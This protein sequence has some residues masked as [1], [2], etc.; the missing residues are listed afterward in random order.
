[1]TVLYSTNSG[2]SGEATN[3]TDYSTLNGT[4]TIP[5]GS[6]TVTL[7]LN[8]VDDSVAEGDETVTLTISSDSHYGPGS[9][10]SATVTIHDDESTVTITATDN[11]ASEPGT[12]KGVFT[13][14]R[15]N[16]G[17]ALAVLYSTNSGQSGAATNGS[18]YSS[19]SGTVTIPSGSSSVALTLIPIDDSVAESD[20]TVTLTISDSSS[21]FKGSPIS[22]TVTIH[23]D[24]PTISITATDNG[25]TEGSDP[26][27]FTI[28]RAGT[29]SGDLAVLYTT[30]SGQ[31]GAS[32]EWQRLL[33]A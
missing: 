6:S 28:T 31:S 23:D 15:D 5:S 7:T 11:S 25:A 19:L 1:M 16:A 2:Q 24:E 21:Y 14:T 12:D 22:A 30:N 10:N 9:S 27:I 17:A 32:H 26:G 33:V 18:D 20:E 13:F 3:G 29:T 4:V 8:P